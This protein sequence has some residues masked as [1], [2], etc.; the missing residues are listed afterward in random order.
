[1]SRSSDSL[2]FTLQGMSCAGCASAIERALKV[3]P[4]V[5]QVAV[6]FPTE[7]ASVVLDPAQATPD[8]VEAAVEKAGYRAHL[9]TGAAYG[10]DQSGRA[11]HPDQKGGQSGTDASHPDD[12]L[13]GIP[14]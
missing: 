13:F 1:M 12:S 11:W 8:T 7:Q 4:G 10:L 9:I 6:N 14:A 2:L 3:T 5:E